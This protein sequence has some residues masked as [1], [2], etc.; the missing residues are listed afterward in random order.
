MQE[1]SRKNDKEIMCELCEMWFHCNCLD[2]TEDT[3]KLLNPE[4]IHFFLQKMD[5]AVG[6]I[7]ETVA[8]LHS[9]REKLW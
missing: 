1:G 8:E 3:Y 6:K 4:G 7:L 9:R 2:V 5:R